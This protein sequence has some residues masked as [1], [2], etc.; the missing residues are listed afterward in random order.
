ML[1]LMFC[2][3]GKKNSSKPDPKKNEKTE[4][5]P[6]VIGMLNPVRDSTAQDILNTFGVKFVLPDGTEN[7][8]YSVIG[9]TLAQVDFTWNGDECTVRAEPSGETSLK[10]I[11]GFYYNWKNSAEVKVGYNTAKAS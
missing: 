8:R 2:G 11:S 3:C 5:Q 7:V 1:A 9:G 6:A 4:I 10:D